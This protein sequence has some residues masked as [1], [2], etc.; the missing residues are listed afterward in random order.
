[1]AWPERRSWSSTVLRP[2]RNTRLARRRPSPLRAGS[3]RLSAPRPSPARGLGWR[4]IPQGRE[5]ACTRSS[6]LRNE[7]PRRVGP[8]QRRPGWHGPG[9]LGTQSSNRELL[10]RLGAADAEELTLGPGPD[11][12]LGPKGLP[13]PRTPGRSAAGLAGP[14]F[15][16]RGR[17]SASL[18]AGAADRGL[19][20][21]PRG[22]WL[23]R[24]EDPRGPGRLPKPGS[25]P[26]PG[27]AP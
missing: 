16:R 24:A 11:W 27:L 26:A 14:S 2:E 21:R 10:S 18:I 25:W 13:S 22:G 1:M 19:P 23:D 20:G 4:R 12:E 7:G 6:R 8:H 3:W 5:Q 15:W 9:L 17:N